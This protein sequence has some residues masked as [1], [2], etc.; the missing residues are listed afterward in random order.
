MCV[1]C[2]R[3]EQMIPDNIEEC[4][5]VNM[6]PE[7]ESRR[8]NYRNSYDEDEGPGRSRVQCASN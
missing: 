2:C 8:R 7:S 1:S 5:L 4:E 6:D 3:P